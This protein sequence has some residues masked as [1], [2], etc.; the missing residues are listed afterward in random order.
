MDRITTTRNR[1]SKLCTLSRKRSIFITQIAIPLGVGIKWSLGEKFSLVAEYGVRKTFTDYLD[2]VG[3]TY[4]DPQY[5]NAEDAI[6]AQLSHQ[7]SYQDIDP[8]TP[9]NGSAPSNA[10]WQA[11]WQQLYQAGSMRRKELMKITG[12]T[13]IHL[14]V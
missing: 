10:D 11:Y 9:V 7:I 6:A 5:L 8:P 13:G 1:G 12:M 3:G 4:A 14:L 2:D